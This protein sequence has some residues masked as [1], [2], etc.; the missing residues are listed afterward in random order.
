[1]SDALDLMANFILTSTG[2]GGVD[3]TKRRGASTTV[4]LHFGGLSLYVPRKQSGHRRRNSC[5]HGRTALAG[6]AV[7]VLD[8]RQLPFRV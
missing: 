2:L 8:S 4:S 6:L 3:G 1:M 5:S 7:A